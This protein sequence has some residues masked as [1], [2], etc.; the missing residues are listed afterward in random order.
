MVEAPTEERCEHWCAEIAALALRE[1][2]DAGAGT[3]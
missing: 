1:L 3:H 2:G